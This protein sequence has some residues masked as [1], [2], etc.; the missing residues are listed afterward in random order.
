MSLPRI[1]CLALVF[2]L[3]GPASAQSLVGDV[4]EYTVRRGDTLTHIGARF[5]VDPFVLTR[6]NG[7]DYFAP[8]H[9]GLK[10]R[11]DNQ[12]IPPPAR[13]TGIVI[14]VPQRMLFLYRDGRLVAHYPV[15]LGQPQWRTPLG[16]FTV[17]SKEL[18][19][20]WVVPES[21]QAEML[22]KGEEVR[23]RV[24]PGPENPLGRHWIGL[25]PGACGIHATIAPPSVYHFQSHG[26]IRMHPD[27]AAALFDLAAVDDPVEILYR[28]LL[29][30]RTPDGGLYLEVHRDIYGRA[31]D[32]GAA[33]LEEARRLKA[34][35]ELDRDRAD[36]VM[37]LRDGLARRV[38][39]RPETEEETLHGPEPTPPADPG[40]RPGR[41]A[42][43]PG[44]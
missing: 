30:T 34:L 39:P 4:R 27:D 17:K 21:I 25:K 12:H 32:P 31:P 40:R 13:E 1:P 6:E 33:L 8:I 11:V 35:D 3:A 43:Q 19:K 41:G 42:A 10:L 26:C 20:E 37:R 36:R 9:P 14:N 29:L 28:P 5:G 15:G 7:L 18:D 2:W 22:A 44:R 24:P 16:R 38:G 23:Q